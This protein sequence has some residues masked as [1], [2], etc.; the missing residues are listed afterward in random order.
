MLQQQQESEQSQ[1]MELIEQQRMQ[2]HHTEIS[3]DDS[4]AAAVG[5]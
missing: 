1:A 2:Y 4:V 3:I 5:M